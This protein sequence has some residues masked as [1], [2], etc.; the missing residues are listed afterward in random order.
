[1]HVPQISLFVRGA[2]ISEN[3]QVT[4]LTVDWLDLIDCFQMSK[5]TNLR[6]LLTCACNYSYLYTCNEFKL[7]RG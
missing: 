6:T 4:K 1:M 5:H 2:V 7:L 3:F